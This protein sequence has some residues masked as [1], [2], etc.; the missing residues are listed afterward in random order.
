M[1]AILA[2]RFAAVLLLAAPGAAAPR[3]HLTRAERESVAYCDH[4]DSACPAGMLRDLHVCGPEGSNDWYEAKGRYEPVC[5]RWGW[6]G[7]RYVPFCEGSKSHPRR[8][9]PWLHAYFTESPRDARIELSDDRTTVC[10][11]K[12]IMI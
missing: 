4:R 10:D 3:H 6:N 1:G 5:E 7:H 8:D 9:D 12:R 2:L 11:R